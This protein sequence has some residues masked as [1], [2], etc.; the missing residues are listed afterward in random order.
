MPSERNYALHIEQKA[1]ETRGLPPTP[2]PS[3]AKISNNTQVQVESGI[4]PRRLF[5]KRRKQR[6]KFKPLPNTVFMIDDYVVGNTSPCSDRI[7]EFLVDRLNNSERV[8]AVV[9]AGISV[10]AGIPD[11]RSSRG[12]FNQRQHG[13]DLFDYNQVYSCN[14]MSAEFHALVKELYQM[15]NKA[16]PTDFHCLLNRLAAENRLLRLYTQNIDDLD[17]KLE[18]LGTE[19]PL[20]GPPGP[21]TIQL[22]GSIHHMFCNK[23]NKVDPIDPNAF[24]DDP[25][26]SGELV[27][28]CPQCE[29]FEAVRNVAGLRLKG[30]GKLR[31][32]VVL[33]NEVHPEG[34]LI[35][36]I[37][38]RDLRKRV[39]CF[40]IAGTSLKIPG[41]K[42]ICSKFAAQA[43]KAGGVILL[44]NK[45][46]PTKS[47]IDSLGYIDVIVLGDCQKIVQLFQ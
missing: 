25:E 12:L 40:I 19:V 22:H 8:I 5:A 34:D 2:P 21:K 41:V 23:C 26:F 3:A 18:H 24:R 27:P 46:M 45:E 28:N 13:K 32:R 1:K 15:S 39:D 35:S 47:M 4:R 29:E 11:F 7:A 33:Y 31:P 6:S 20:A 44:F 42:Q 43:H 14:K 16:D 30:I 17:V 38:N 37:T 10:A 36:Q 9:G